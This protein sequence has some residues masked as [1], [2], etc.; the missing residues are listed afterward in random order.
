MRGRTRR[1]A[2]VTPLHDLTV[3][4]GTATGGYPTSVTK[5]EPRGADLAAA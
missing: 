3:V 2:T 1:T 4:P 5:Y